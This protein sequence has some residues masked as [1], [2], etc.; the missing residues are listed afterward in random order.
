MTQTNDKQTQHH[1]EMEK[2]RRLGKAED[3]HA[4]SGA[5]DFEVQVRRSTPSMSRAK[6]SPRAATIWS[7]SRV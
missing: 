3:A 5:M 7:L 6:S 2:K 1:K 4:A